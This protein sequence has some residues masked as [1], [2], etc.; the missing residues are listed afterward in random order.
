MKKPLKPSEYR[1]KRRQKKIE[2]KKM[3]DSDTSELY[4]TVDLNWNERLLQK[5]IGNNND[6]NFRRFQLPT[7]EQECLLVFVDGLVKDEAITDSILRNLMLELP[8][9]INLQEK[10]KEHINAKDLE[11]LLISEG[12]VA[13]T[14]NIQE[15]VDQ[16]L[17]GE[18]AV[19]LEGE[20]QAALIDTR[21]W[22]MRGIEDAS[23]ESVIR[24][25]RESFT[26]TLRINTSLIRRKI[27]SSDLKIEALN[28]G[29]KTK[30]DI[31]IAYLEGVVN[32]KV[33]EEVKKRLNRIDIDSVLESGYLE[34][35]IEDSPL[36]PFP[37]IQTTE[38]PDKVAANIL[39][40]RVA[41]I[42][43]HTPF[44]MLVP[45]VF[46]QFFQASEDYYERSMSS[47]VLR[48]VRVLAYIISL[49]LPA[50]YVATI[51]FHQQLIPFDLA[52]SIAEG[53]AGVP[54]P[55]FLEAFLMGL[56]FEILR[57][58][59]V[60][61]PKPVGQ[62]VGIVG[63]LVLG[64]AAVTAGLVSP[65]M[66]IVAA[67][68]AIASFALPNYSLIISSTIIRLALMLLSAFMGYY[69]LIWGLVAVLIHLVSL[70]SFGVPYM[71]PLAPV[72]TG[73]LKDTFFR[74]PWWLMVSRPHLIGTKNQ[75]RGKRQMPH[76]RRGRGGQ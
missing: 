7:V 12:E 4:L 5:F 16:V 50:F 35:L 75:K 71:S 56:I 59:G 18:A 32:P 68:T 36:S 20:N 44:V 53:R 45:T 40:G 48:G 54:F 37:Q 9:V 47:N 64:E 58:A 25:P 72:S 49:A 63:G 51:N 57:E 73:G 30:T 13:L 17:S 52:L 14:G 27:R 11:M 74:V 22:E 19:I 38:R 21:G 33:A 46:I 66:V 62:A 28:L 70:R 34:E 3:T 8:K 31:A 55:P 15:I 39:E 65:I 42:V 41:I 26:E 6:I 60:R 23:S 67:L 10:K 1:S 61:L 76:P 24:G 2:D 43:D 69:G 29:T